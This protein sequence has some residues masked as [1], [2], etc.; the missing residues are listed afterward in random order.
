[1]SDQPTIIQSEKDYRNTPGGQY[2]RWLAEMNAADKRTSEWHKQGNRIQ[3]RYQDRRGME[4]TR[5]AEMDNSNQMRVN[6]FHS[7]VA[8]LKS[9]LFG[10]IPKVEVARRYA[11]ADDDVARVGSL[12]LGRMLNNSVYSKDEGIQECFGHLLEDRLLPGLAVARIRYDYDS[13]DREVEEMKDDEGN[14]LAEGYTTSDLLKE[15]ALVDYV[16]WDDFR[17]GYARTWKEVPWIAFRSFL[18][19]DQATDRFGENVANQLEYSK[20]SV[21]MVSEKRLSSDEVTDAHERAEVW[22]IWEKKKKC[23]WWWS[24]G[25]EGICDKQSD[26][27]ELYGFWPCP[28]PWIANQVSS[29][30]LPQPDFAI[31]QDLYNEI[32]QLETRIGIITEAVRVVGVYD[33]NAEGIARMLTEGC[34]NELIPVD[35]WSMFAEKGGIEGQVSFLPLKDISEALLKLVEMRSDAMSLLYEVT[36]MSEIMRGKD[37]PDRETEGAAKGKRR[38][39]SIRVQA[40]QEEFS[41][42]ISDLMCLK[43]EVISKHFDPA[44]IMKQSNIRHT[45]DAKADPPLVQAALDLIKTPDEMGWRIEIKPESIAMVDYQDLQESRVKFLDALSKVLRGSAPLLQLDPRAMPAIMEMLKWTL[46]GFRGSQEMEGVVDRAIEE[47]KKPKPPE[48]EDN[49]EKIKAQSEREKEQHAERMENLKHQNKMNELMAKAEADIAELRHELE[50]QMQ[51]IREEALK[52]IMIEQAQAEAAM[53]QDDHETTNKIKVEKAK[54]K[55][56]N[57][58][59][60]T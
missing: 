53:E 11:D 57:G 15:D 46:A 8:T 43:A 28:K 2:Q 51:L 33:K 9:M 16:H 7:N 49:S 58:S 54:P 47:L 4:T 32:D 37:G 55:V 24:R 13:E 39:A 30:F 59:A 56:K 60:R 36:S 38:F 1:M 31:A 52:D 45:A 10:N 14:I 20:K 12:M 19:K 25:Y 40:M 29:M 50:T 18:T 35:N 22:E 6:L 27:L 3:A 23:V 44:T 17:W 41:R 21:K 42:F 48:Q 5:G 26:P 34:E